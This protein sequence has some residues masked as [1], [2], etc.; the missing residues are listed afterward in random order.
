MAQLLLDHNN[1]SI[2]AAFGITKEREEEI[3][4]FIQER[5][6][7]RLQ[8]TEIIEA[9]H[10]NDSF[11][12]NETIYLIFVLG[13]YLESMARRRSL[14]EDPMVGLMRALGGISGHNPN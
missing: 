13:S 14:E 1:K 7:K 2:R 5:I 11:T 4:P 9:V 12:Y 8:V 6:D 3:I 10:D